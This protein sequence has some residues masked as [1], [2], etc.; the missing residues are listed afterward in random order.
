MALTAGVW[1]KNAC[2]EATDKGIK[3]SVRFVDS[4]MMDQ[5]A[6]L[7][8]RDQLRR[9]VKELKQQLHECN[10]RFNRECNGLLDEYE[11]IV[12]SRDELIKE[13][14]VLKK[15][16]KFLKSKSPPV[17][18]LSKVVESV[19]VAT[20]PLCEDV[21][22]KKGKRYGK[23]EMQLKQV[24]EVERKTTK[25][26]TKVSYDANNEEDVEYIVCK[27]GGEGVKKCM[28]T[29]A[30][31][32][33]HY[34]QIVHNNGYHNGVRN[35]CLAISLS[36]GLSRITNGRPANSQE[37]DEMIKA[38]GCKGYMM[39]VSDLD[40]LVGI[41]NKICAPHA[42]NVHIFERLLNGSHTHYQSIAHSPRAS[43]RDKCIVLSW[44]RGAH[45]E[46]MVKT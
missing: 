23:S 7:K 8:E 21:K 20:V 17:P 30:H 1:K 38:L 31:V 4:Q 15:E 29:D 27:C 32:N 35:A 11:K 18:N 45:F 39:D 10:E 40:V 24:S 12:Q 34:T 14:N 3:K 5:T 13:N 43:T 42:I 44:V 28:L 46:L 36:D 41:F 2:F 37:K 19:I 16:N 25:K 33:K 26:P 22:D 9:E 6:L